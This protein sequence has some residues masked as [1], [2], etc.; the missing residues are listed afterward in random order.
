M[1]S[2]NTFEDLYQL[3]IIS[4]YGANFFKYTLILNFTCIIFILAVYL[5]ARSKCR[6]N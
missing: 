4:H 6:S 1:D 5:G 2:I 3:F